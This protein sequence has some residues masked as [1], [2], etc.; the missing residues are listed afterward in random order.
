[1]AIIKNPLLQD[2]CGRV[3]KLVFFFPKW[4]NIYEAP[5][6]ISKIKFTGVKTIQGKIQIDDA[7]LKPA[8]A[9][10]LPNTQR[11]C[12]GKCPFHQNLF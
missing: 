3:G 6:E 7:I 11:R 8:Q 5:G 12:P 9:I 10:H 1:M 2:V 4:K